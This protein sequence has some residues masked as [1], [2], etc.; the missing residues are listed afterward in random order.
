MDERLTSLK[1]SKVVEHVIIEEKAKMLK[2]RT[3]G[4]TQT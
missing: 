3:I 2:K 4:E 1:L